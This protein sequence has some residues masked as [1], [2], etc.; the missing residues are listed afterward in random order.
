MPIGSTYE[1]QGAPLPVFP[2][3][4]GPVDPGTGLPAGNGGCGG[5][6]GA[7]RVHFWQLL[8]ATSVPGATLGVAG[9]VPMAELPGPPAGYQYVLE[10]AIVRGPSALGLWVIVGDLF[11]DNQVDGI[12]TSITD[13]ATMADGDSAVRV[14]PGQPLRFVWL[15]DPAERFTAR[16]QYRQ[17]PA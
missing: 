3:A 1:N 9:N 10:R 2:G 13:F 7:E 15:G 4:G 12:P 5:C 17:E 11:L 14:P 8:T 6:G 16:V